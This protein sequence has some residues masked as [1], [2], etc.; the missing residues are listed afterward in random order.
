[1]NHHIDFDNDIGMSGQSQHSS[2]SLDY[3]SPFERSIFHLRHDPY[4]YSSFDKV[5]RGPVWPC[6][7][8]LW[9]KTPFVSWHN[10]CTWPYSLVHSAASHAYGDVN[11]SAV[12]SL[13]LNNIVITSY[14]D[15]SLTVPQRTAWRMF[16]LQSPETL[17]VWSAASIMAWH[18]VTRCFEASDVVAMGKA[19]WRHA[20][21]HWRAITVADS[22]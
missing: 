20:V 13:L 17:D 6:S 21:H 22:A 7:V 9:P 15:L 16:F 8:D 19:R 5:V 4:P 2:S 18:H 1:M 14:L 12:V 10:A 3:R 11:Y